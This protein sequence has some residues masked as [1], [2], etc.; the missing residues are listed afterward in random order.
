ML[1]HLKLQESLKKQATYSQEV[2]LLDE[3]LMFTSGKVP[4]CVLGLPAREGSYL[5]WHRFS[6]MR[7]RLAGIFSRFD[8]LGPTKPRRLRLCH[9]SLVMSLSFFLSSIHRSNTACSQ[10]SGSAL[11]QEWD[12]HFAQH[13]FNISIVFNFPLPLPTSPENNFFLVLKTWTTVK[14]DVFLHFAGYFLQER[15]NRGSQSSQ[16]L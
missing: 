14:V 6:G 9:T 16:G 8:S 5:S 10:P 4:G 2:N 12:I 7:P 15:Q 3:Y 13:S 11:G 1:L